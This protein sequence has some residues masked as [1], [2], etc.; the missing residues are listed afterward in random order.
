MASLVHNELRYNYL[1]ADTELSVD[2][3]CL[4][5]G[6]NHHVNFR[7]PQANFGRSC[8][9]NTISNLGSF[10]GSIEP[11]LRQNFT[12]APL[13]FRGPGSLSTRSLRALWYLPGMVFRWFSTSWI[14]MENWVFGNTGRPAMSSSDTVWPRPEKNMKCVYHTQIKIS[15]WNSKWEWDES[16]KCM[17]Y[18]HGILSHVNQ[19]TPSNF[20]GRGY[21]KN[22]GAVSANS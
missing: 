8:H 20:V 12:R 6:A 17:W 15:F 21:K 19:Y 3:F 11:S 7:E 22:P 5:S 9:R 1:I 16:I 2:I 18:H 13:D 4:G 10:V 14:H